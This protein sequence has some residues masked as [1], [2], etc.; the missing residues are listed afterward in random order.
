M[1]KVR[2]VLVTHECDTPIEEYLIQ[3]D[4]FGVT[5]LFCPTH[6]QEVQRIEMEEIDE[7]TT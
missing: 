5:G 6:N 3:L 4:E 2:P 7:E 1:K